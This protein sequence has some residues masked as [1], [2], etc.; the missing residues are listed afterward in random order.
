MKIVF[1]LLILVLCVQCDS[2]TQLSSREKVQDFEFLYQTLKDNYP[3]FGVAKRQSGLDWLS[4]K[5]EYINRIK[6]TP[7][8]S[9][10]F[11]T[12]NSIINDLQ[13]PHVGVWPTLAHKF[14][15][16]LYKGAIAEKPK[17]QKWFDVLDDKNERSGYWLQIWENKWGK[18]DRTNQAS[19]R[20][21][22]DSLLVDDHIA[23][24][25]FKTFFYDDVTKDTA[26]V[27]SF[28]DRIR[29][30]EY[31]IIDIQ[32]NGG[33]SSNSWKK[34][35]VGRMTEL[36]VIFPRY[37]VIKDG[38][39]NRHFYPEAFEKGS[40]AK[41]ENALFINTPDEILDGTYFLD[42][43]ND[44]I[45]PNHPKP[46]KGKI[47]LLVNEIVFSA[48]EDFAYFCKV[49]K[50][51]TIAGVRTGGDGACG[52]PT[53]FMLPKSGITLNHPSLVG[54]NSDGSLNFETRTI[55]EVQI[56]G[57]NPDERLDN[58]VKY[59]KGVD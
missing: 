44:T 23:I 14:M 46:F 21:Y 5:G 4:K 39:L 43:R 30:F 1:L 29:D 16:D 50:W 58:L 35:I 19:T 11:F 6:A 34:H 18:Y 20:Y 54:L 48:S 2:S 10:Y 25:R 56:S 38:A 52:E 15:A 42:S 12:L 53:L 49:A 31:L 13:N 47:F 33:G 36:P 57:R 27:T 55:P 41:K 26:L 8:D 17:Y 7:N 22:T 9:A 3:F 45:V 28:L 40:F 51:A 37:Q 59:I 24:M 32:D